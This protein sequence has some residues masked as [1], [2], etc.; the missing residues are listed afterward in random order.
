MKRSIATV[1]ERVEALDHE[2]NDLADELAHATMLLRDE[3]Q[4]IAP[5]LLGRIEMLNQEIQKTCADLHTWATELERI[6]LPNPAAASV[7]RARQLLLQISLA[8]ADISRERDAAIAILDQVAGIVNIDDPNFPALQACQSDALALRA[9]LLTVDPPELHPEARALAQ[10]AHPFAR[11]VAILA[12]TLRLDD[13]TYGAYL[14]SVQQSFGRALEIALVRHR[15]ALH[16]PEPTDEPPASESPAATEFATP[17]P[18]G[19]DYDRAP[20]PELVPS[21]PEPA[22]DLNGSAPASAPDEPVE[23]GAPLQSA[24]LDEPV[25]SIYVPALEDQGPWLADPD[26]VVE[27][28]A[29]TSAQPTADIGDQ[30]LFAPALPESNEQAEPIEQSAARQRAGQLLAQPAKR[31]D[32]ALPE[33]VF[34]LLAEQRTSLAYHLARVCEQIGAEQAGA[35]PAWLVRALALGQHLHA[36][37]SPIANDLKDCFPNA[38][39]SQALDQPA[40]HKLAQTLLIMAATLP[41]AMLAPETGAADVLHYVAADPLP[42]Q[43]QAL[44]GA[45]GEFFKTQPPIDE[46][47]MRLLHEQAGWRQEWE[48]LRLDAQTFWNEVEHKRLIYVPATEVWQN[49]TK[50]DG[51]IYRM[52]RPLLDDNQRLLPQALEAVDSLRTPR[53]IRRE[54]HH[55]HRQVLGRGFGDDIRDTALVQI[56]TLALDAVKLTQHWAR[57]CDTRPSPDLKERLDQIAALRELV[58]GSLEPVRAELAALEQASPATPALRCALGWC[59]QALER[60]ADVLQRTSAAP[61]AALPVHAILH[62]PLL[63]TTEIVCDDQWEPGPVTAAFAEALLR[64][65]AQD[66]GTWQGALDA[67]HAADDHRATERIIEYLE[68]LGANSATVATLRE[69][70]EL[71]LRWLRATLRSQL[72]QARLEL[73]QAISYGLTREDD[74]LEYEARIQNLKSAIQSLRRLAAARANIEQLR[75]ALNLKIDAGIA[76]VEQSLGRAPLAADHPAR[77]WIRRALEQRDPLTANE[78]LTLALEGHALPTSNTKVDL[79]TRFFLNDFRGITDYLAT[80]G[81]PWTLIQRLREVRDPKTPHQLGPVTIWPG[82]Q[83]FDAARLIEAWYEARRTLSRPPPQGGW[84][85]AA[86]EPAVRNVLDYLGFT[87]KSVTTHDRPSRRLWLSVKTEV[88]HDKDLCPVR[89]YGSSAAG[90]Y[91]LLIVAD[92]ATEEEIITEINDPSKGMPPIIVFYFGRLLE[93]QRRALA[94][95]CR[96]KHRTCILIDD[97]LMLFLSEYQPPRLGKLFA[98]TLPFTYLEP[99]VTT[100]SVVPYEVFYGRQHEYEEI[101]DPMGSCFLF[102]GRQIGKTALLRHVEDSAHDPSKGR[103]VRWIDLKAESIGFKLPL[104]TIWDVIARELRPF[105]VFP[106]SLP[107]NTRAEGYFKHIEA[108]LQADPNRRIVLLLDEA[109]HFLYSDGPYQ[110]KHQQA[111]QRTSGL[112]GLMDRTNRRFKVVFAGLHNIQ[113]TARQ[114][115]NPLAHYG[116]PLRIGPLLDDGEWRQARNLI[117]Q[118]MGSLGYRFASDDLVTRILSQTNY[119]PGLLQLYGAEMVR[120]FNE[121]Y[122][123]LFAADESPP[124]TITSKH[125]EAIYHSESLHENIRHRFRLTLQL[126]RRYEI[127]TYVVAYNAL[128]DEQEVLLKGLSVS[129][130]R[131]QSLHYWAQG[132]AQDPSEEMFLTLLEELIGLGI[133]RRV[134]GNRFTLRNANM[135]LLVG[136]QDQVLDELKRER[137]LPPGYDAATFRSSFTTDPGDRSGPA[138]RSPITAKQESDLRTSGHGVTIVFGNAAAGMPSLGTFLRQ[139]LGTSLVIELPDSAGEEDFSLALQNLAQRER[140]GTTLL[141]VPPAAGWH[142]AW[143]HQAHS[144]VSQ[145]TSRSDFARVVFLADP[146]HTWKLLSQEGAALEQVLANFARPI[147]LMPWQDAAVH[148]WIIDLGIE[149]NEQEGRAKLAQITSNWPYMLLRY[150]QRVRDAPTRWKA[151]LETM[152]QEIEQT[153]LQRDLVAAL[154]LTPKEP[155]QVLTTIAELDAERPIAATDLIYL[156]ADELAPQVVQQSLRWADLLSLVAPSGPNQWSLQRLVAR[157]LLGQKKVRE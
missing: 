47:T 32:R 94:M 109:D 149:P 68:G 117:E 101:L 52:L 127:I 112:K 129:A 75:S 49:W 5:V 72:E 61:S 34:L 36:A 144:S 113:R 138:R 63:R 6:D 20:A 13:A 67:H 65:I 133:F 77:Q 110:A 62:G 17:E 37:R 23:L 121:P 88:L 2:C 98:C 150:Y 143:A 60:A 48:N 18:L 119:Y 124:Y 35:P 14:D 66:D 39:E 122:R 80:N 1:M 82:P 43:T 128:D 25:A 97:T 42:P 11:L 55:T 78:Y 137:E 69:R 90:Q 22:H 108:W 132:F 53:H 105:E 111:F 147:N 140:N 135:L 57:L 76:R 29:L 71:Q 120:H 115:N 89:T 50:P 145:L 103:I 56:Q 107:P 151:T 91:R 81:D 40:A 44:C 106:R 33:L 27:R 31:R 46:A 134:Q 148:Q 10:G 146:A 125:L 28:A 92:R 95:L 84:K 8:E 153:H 21:A 157:V 155:V 7:L 41:A 16:Q 9:A 99:Y 100:A 30:E 73:A 51:Y 86:V 59:R 58:L 136:S 96:E 141:L 131:E 19:N 54:I 38:L 85:M 4:P 123:A 15:L 154:G 102:G 24:A 79:F 64:V 93:H 116:Q 118:P 139:T 130:I 87:T 3:G 104:D 142:T 156:M 12:D 83:A 26:P 152:E 114:E 74:V 126:D 45:I 70:R